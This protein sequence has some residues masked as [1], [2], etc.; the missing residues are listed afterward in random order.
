M[1]LYLL[2]TS[3]LIRL[4]Q[5]SNLIDKW[6]DPIQAGALSI[7]PVTELEVLITAKNSDHRHEII[8]SMDEYYISVFMPDRVYER[9]AEVQEMLTAKGQHRS[10][11]PVDLLVA[12]TAELTGRTLVHYDKDF[13]VVA[14]FTK[15][16]TQWLTKPGDVA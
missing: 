14:Q 8:G 10:A 13:E 15:Q 11:G 3:A 6:R 1:I 7:C 9:A 4:H 5:H 16:P 12:A 2:D